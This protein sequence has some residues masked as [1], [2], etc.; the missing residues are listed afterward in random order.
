[1]RGQADARVVYLEVDRH[2]GPGALVPRRAHDHFAYARELDR[3]GHE[4]DQ[5]LA[6]PAGISDHD[7]GDARLHVEDELDALVR[8]GLGEQLDRLLKHVLGAELDGFQAQPAGLDLREIENVVD[9]LEQR[10]AG[11]PDRLHVLMLLGRQLGFEQQAGHA[12]DPVHRCPDLVTHRG[13]ELG[14]QAGQLLQLLV[15]L[16]QV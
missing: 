14:L 11:C 2:P 12:D 4:I 16:R 9:D 6:E 7:I 13:E 10:V 5:H 1:M 8:G 3:V 15:A